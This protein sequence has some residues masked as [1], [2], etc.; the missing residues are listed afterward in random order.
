MLYFILLIQNAYSK[1][2]KSVFDAKKIKINQCSE[3]ENLMALFNFPSSLLKISKWGLLEIRE[4]GK[5]LWFIE[6]ACLRN[7]TEQSKIIWFEISCLFFVFIFASVKV[8]TGLACICKT[9][10]FTYS[11]MSSSDE[12]VINWRMCCQC[13]SSSRAL[14][15]YLK[16]S[17]KEKLN[18]ACCTFFLFRGSG[19]WYI[20]LPLRLSIVQKEIHYT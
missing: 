1:N 15:K 13:S 18:L 9:I 3:I 16:I 10:N 11:L 8:L 5:H 4:N 17:T 6:C 12:D 14:Q 19:L 7:Y 2:S 20:L